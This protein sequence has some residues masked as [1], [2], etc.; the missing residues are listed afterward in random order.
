MHAMHLLLWQDSDKFHG[1]VGL[2][3]GHAVVAGRK[4]CRIYLEV[5]LAVFVLGLLC[6][7]VLR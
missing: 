4:A 5:A 3:R 7:V 6:D 1:D 2:A